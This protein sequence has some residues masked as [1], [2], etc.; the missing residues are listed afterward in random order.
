M[1]MY[2]TSLTL[3]ILLLSG[4]CTAAEPAKPNRPS[5]ETDE[6]KLRLAPNTPNQMAGFYTGRGFPQFAIDEVSKLCFITVGLRN[7]SNDTVWLDVGN[8]RFHTADGE[9]KRYER[10]YWK[11]RWAELGLEKRFQ[12]TFRWTLVP[13]KLDFHPG[14]GEGGNIVLP[15][16]AK[17]ITVTASIAVG[18]N[19]TKVY[20][21]KIENLYC[22]YDE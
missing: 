14:E 6:F 4:F 9:L 5:F 3:L 10:S 21:I 18:S 17:P 7:K 22:A 12:S 15:R 13:E 19:K 16:T 1:P 8:W 20:D 11:Q 2:K